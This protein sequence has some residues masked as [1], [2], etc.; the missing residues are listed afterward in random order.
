LLQ[1]LLPTIPEGHRDF[2]QNI[3]E[4]G[5]GVAQQYLNVS[6]PPLHPDIP[7]VLSTP[8]ATTN[9]SSTTT[10]TKNRS[11]PKNAEFVQILKRLKVRNTTGTQDE[12]YTW[13]VLWHDKGK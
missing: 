11:R 7:P 2:L 13:Q 4:G 12:N 10:S 8:T 6:L 3:N 9:T 5:S 1:S